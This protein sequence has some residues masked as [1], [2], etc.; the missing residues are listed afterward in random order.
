[1]TMEVQ[2]AASAL[3]GLETV[4]ESHEEEDDDKSDGE[5]DREE[6]HDSD[7]EDGPENNEYGDK[8]AELFN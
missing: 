3:V 6:S 4:T 2:A 5:S 8:E 1:M 7:D